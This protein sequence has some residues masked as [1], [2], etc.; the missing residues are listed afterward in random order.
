MR[1]AAGKPG[2]HIIL[3]GMDGS[4]RKTALH[5][6]LLML[7]VEVF[8]VSRAEEYGFDDWRS[9][10]KAATIKVSASF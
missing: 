1:G 6:A 8:V 2:G 3:V 7:E 10:L 4:G 9:D 5:L